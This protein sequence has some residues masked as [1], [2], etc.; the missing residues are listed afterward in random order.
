MRQAP[1][2]GAEAIARAISV[3]VKNFLNSGVVEVDVHFEL[4]KL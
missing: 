4:D 3:S 1:W 2:L